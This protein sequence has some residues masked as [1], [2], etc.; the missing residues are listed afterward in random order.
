MTAP[1]GVAWLL[2]AVD[3]DALKAWQDVAIGAVALIVAAYS[4]KRWLFPRWRAIVA[5]FVAVR[6]AILGRDAILDSITGEQLAPAQKGLGPRTAELERGME[7]LSIAVTKLADQNTAL[8]SVTR[9]VSDLQTRVGRLEAA[10]VERVVTKV[11]STAAWSAV[12]AV[13]KTDSTGRI[14]GDVPHE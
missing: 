3:L 7:L 4:G 5:Q 14:P 13:A 6:D 12:E 8:I 10:S 2:A 9:D 1:S 11:E